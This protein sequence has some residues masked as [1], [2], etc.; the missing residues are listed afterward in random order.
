MESDFE[1]MSAS[2]A[3]RERLIGESFARL[4]GRSLLEPDADP[5]RALWSLPAVVVAHGTQD[6]PLFFYGNRAAL[7]LFEMTAS[8]FI[9]LPSRKSAEP[10]ERSERARLMDRV[11]R[12]GFIDD[13]SG[14][15]ISSTGQRFRI[16]Q[17]VVWNLI[18]GD[19]RYCGQAATFECWTML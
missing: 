8:A 6:D 15:R 9:R 14:I 5:A 13:Y 11:T 16:E 4:I 10:L 12:Q 17:A 18:D 1:I 7:D 19:G 3:G 2:A